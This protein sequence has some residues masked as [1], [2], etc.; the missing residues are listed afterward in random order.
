METLRM[1]NYFD[2]H[3]KDIGFS[4]KIKNPLSQYYD[5][6]NHD[7]FEYFFLT[8]GSTGHIINGKKEILTRGNLVFIRP[9]DC[10]GFYKLEGQEF[11]IINITI[12][13]SEFRRLERYL[14]CRLSE[15]MDINRPTPHLLLMD[16][17]LQSLLDAHSFLY[18][19]SLSP[20]NN[21]RL[22]R[23]MRF[24]LMRVCELFLYSG[25]DRT[26]ATKQWLEKALALMNTPD[27]IEKGLPAL[28]EVTGFSHGHLCR[29]MNRY[30]NTTPNA[31]IVELRLNQAAS[32]LRYSK[33]SVREVSRKVG[34]VNQSHFMKIFKEK[35]GL[36][37]LQYRKSLEMD[38]MFR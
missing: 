7:F 3:L 21:M 33:M 23:R 17:N 12:S 24:L 8:S 31:Y 25:L 38:H 13:Q 30:F 6:H 18:F 34:Y 16:S 10:H 5:I 9:N 28:L 2:T 11:E 20:E 15:L 4:F 14:G 22:Q 37:P 19:F 1:E 27:N 35:Y 36:S 32:L 29:L 26:D